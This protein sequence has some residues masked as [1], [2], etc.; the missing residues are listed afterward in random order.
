MCGQC[1]N[2]DAI[3]R[4][5]VTA[6]YGIDLGIEQRKN[7]ELKAIIVCMENAKQRPEYCMLG[8]DSK[9]VELCGMNEILFQL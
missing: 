9:M 6:I 7:P 2:V 5:P 3:A 8:K 4:A 1:G